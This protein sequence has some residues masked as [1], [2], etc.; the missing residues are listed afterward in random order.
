MDCS[1]SSVLEPGCTAL[2]FN[3]LKMD[4]GAAVASTGLGGIQRDLGWKSLVTYGS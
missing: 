2:G 3:G 1:F 4:S